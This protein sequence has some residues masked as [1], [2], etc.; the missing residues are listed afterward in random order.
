MRIAVDFDGT[1]NEDKYPDIGAPK[2]NII[3]WCI[4][5]KS[6]GHQIG[7]YTV[8]TGDLLSKAVQ[9]CYEQGLDF[10]Y[11]ILNKPH[12]DV[13]LDDKNMKVSD[14]NNIDDIKNFKR[15]L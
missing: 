9:W 4:K 12:V 13:F 10:N 1:L 14:I 2:Q 8:R 5:Q 15:G 7:L 3:D 11:I 6:L